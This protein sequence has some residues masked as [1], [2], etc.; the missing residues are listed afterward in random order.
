MVSVRIADELS[1]FG[2]TND[3]LCNLGRQEAQQDIESAKRAQQSA[4]EQ[5]SIA[6]NELRKL[7]EEYASSASKL[8]QSLQQAQVA[9]AEAEAARIQAISVKSENQTSLAALIQ[10]P[11][12]LHLHS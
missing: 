7:R 5:K 9:M 4:E 10:V 3:V 2:T 8:A 6:T 1:S 12:I 11:P